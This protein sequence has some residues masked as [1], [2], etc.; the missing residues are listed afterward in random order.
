MRGDQKLSA[1]LNSPGGYDDKM[2]VVDASDRGE[3]RGHAL[4]LLLDLARTTLFL[5]DGSAGSLES[6]LDSSR[7]DT[8]PHPFH[9]RE[10][11]SCHAL[12]EF[13]RGL[14]TNGR[15]ATR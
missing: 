4:P 5:H 2:V 12:I 14:E 8:A 11:A 9:V 1:I 3:K 13:L 15:R 7:G 6:L 10:A